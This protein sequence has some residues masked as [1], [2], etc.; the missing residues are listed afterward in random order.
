MCHS[1]QSH[2]IL[3]IGEPHFLLAHNLYYGWKMIRIHE[4]HQRI[5]GEFTGHPYELTWH[6]GYCTL[7]AE[8]CDQ[9]ITLDVPVLEQNGRKPESTSFRVYSYV[10][11]GMHLN[12]FI[13][14]DGRLQPIDQK[15]DRPTYLVPAGFQ[16]KDV[17]F[18]DGWNISVR[19]IWIP[20]Y[21][22]MVPIQ[23]LQT[24]RGE[25]EAAFMRLLALREAMTRED[26]KTPTNGVSRS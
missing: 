17:V 10:L 7:R 23:M 13:Y 6:Q 25:F 19:Q 12:P 15:V 4:Q 18:F 20:L 22:E 26:A 24:A 3:G 9:P 14:K 21:T 11:A 5:T 8:A 2:T 16:G 1:I